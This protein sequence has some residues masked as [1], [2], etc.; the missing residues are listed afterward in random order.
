MMPAPTANAMPL[1]VRVLRADE[2]DAAARL[3]AASSLLIPG[4]AH[5]HTPDQDRAFYR[6]QV[7]RKGPIWGAFGHGRLVGHV[8]LSPGWV[9]HLYVAPAHNGKGVGRTLIE[10][11]QREQDELQ[12][13]TFQSNA[14]ARRFYAANG[15]VEEELGDGSGNEEGMPDVRL[16]WR[17]AS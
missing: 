4:Y 11:A 6:E 8:A 5:D 2:T 9:D 7:F 17:R 15:F 14:R 3:H 16:R 1:T 13:Y 10:R 12:L